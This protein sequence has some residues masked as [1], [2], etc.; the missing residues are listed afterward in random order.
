MMA[1]DVF[2]FLKIIVIRNLKIPQ[3]ARRVSKETF[4]IEVAVASRQFNSKTVGP[5]CQSSSMLKGMQFGTESCSLAN[6]A[7]CENL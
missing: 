3:Q 2:R 4:R 1:I 5:S 6:T 7:F